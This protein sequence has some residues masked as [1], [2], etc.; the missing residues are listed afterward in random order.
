MLQQKKLLGKFRI[1]GILIVET[2]LHIGGGEGKMDIGGLDKPVAR[3]PITQYPYLP[4][5]SIKG[6]L[7]SL[8]ER[9]HNKPLN[10]AGSRDTFRYESDDLVDGYTELHTIPYTG[11]RT[12]PISRL[13]G[14]TG[15]S[16]FWVKTTD[17][18]AENLDRVKQNDQFVTE[19]YSGVEY[20]KI[21]R[22]RNSP[23][24]IIVRDCRLS[25]ES[26]K[27]L[28]RVDTGLY[29]T[30]WKWENGLDRV[31]AAANPRQI[32]RVPAGA[33]FDFEL[34]YTVEAEG[35]QTDDLTPEELQKAFREAA[36]D[37]RN[38]AIALSLLEDDALGGHG[39][40]G[41]GKI[42]FKNYQC[43]WRDLKQYLQVVKDG[44][45]FKQPIIAVEDTLNL[46]K[47][48]GNLSD[49]MQ[50]SLPGN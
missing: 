15:G 32:E 35:S 24:K 11:A 34:V 39:S 10:R 31:T 29:M 3:D 18:I 21:L 36:E 23:A 47:K 2:G 13:F 28:E 4:G 40:R 12:C 41:Y 19:I 9:V 37:L 25:E 5:S 42:R 22:G 44:V 17:A 16:D 1:E 49:E 38:I 8:L 43:F 14:S 45:E 20:S 27:K 50:I 26:A 7:R 30:E 6:K 48:F 33:E 46:L